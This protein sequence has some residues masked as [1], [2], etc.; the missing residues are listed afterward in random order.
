MVDCG[1]PRA[2][3]ALEGEKVRNCTRDILNGVYGRIDVLFPAYSSSHALNT[4]LVTNE[5]AYLNKSIPVVGTWADAGVLRCL[6]ITSWASQ[7]AGKK[8]VSLFL[9]LPPPP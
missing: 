9:V 2:N 4:F 6:N 3:A 7:C 1:V 5:P 8:V